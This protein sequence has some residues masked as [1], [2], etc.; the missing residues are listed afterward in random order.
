MARYNYVAKIVN[1]TGEEVIL[2]HYCKGS[3]NNEDPD[4]NVGEVGHL[5][6]GEMVTPPTQKIA[7]GA[8]GSFVA[9]STGST[10][11]GT[12]AYNISGKRDPVWMWF[13]VPGLGSQHRES[14]GVFLE[15]LDDSDHAIASYTLGS[16]AADA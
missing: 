13:H 3:S 16:G 10:I 8:E 5:Y 11:Q 14:D 6:H 15:I 1:N 7:A 4:Q 9:K 2:Q 12:V